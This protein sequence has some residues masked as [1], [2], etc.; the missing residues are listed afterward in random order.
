MPRAPGQPRHARL[1]WHMSDA[2]TLMWIGVTLRSR[3]DWVAS[4]R[5]SALRLSHGRPAVTLP[6]RSRQSSLRRRCLCLTSG[7]S[8]TFT[9]LRM[10]MLQP[11]QIRVD[12]VYAGRQP[13]CLQMHAALTFCQ[14]RCELNGAGNGK[15]T[16]TPTART[17]ALGPSSAEVIRETM[18]PPT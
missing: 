13:A 5:Q 9:V 6:V 1:C 17:T 11:V 14:Q 10:M 2:L 12:A 15:T 18:S 16:A 4:M 8:G 3:L 7:Y